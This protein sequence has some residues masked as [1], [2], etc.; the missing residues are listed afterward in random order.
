MHSLSTLLGL[1]MSVLNSMREVLGIAGLM[2]AG[3]TDLV[4]AILE[5]IKYHKARLAYLVRM[6]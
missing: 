2:G 4:R 5:P 6:L 1:T 3:R